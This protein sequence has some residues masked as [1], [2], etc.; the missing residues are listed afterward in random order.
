MPVSEL[1]YCHHH[2]IVIIHPSMHCVIATITILPSYLYLPIVVAHIW[3]PEPCI[4]HHILGKWGWV[5]ITH[6][7]VC[8][9]MHI[10]DTPSVWY[11]PN[12]GIINSRVWLDGCVWCYAIALGFWKKKPHPGHLI[13]W[14]PDR[15]VGN[16]VKSPNLYSDKCPICDRR[17][18]WDI[19]HHLNIG[20]IANGKQTQFGQRQ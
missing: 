12:D 3:V 19:N 1:W 7:A 14:K 5:H 15:I 8:L 6:T 4:N 11:G 18:Q 16:E 2:I 20:A 9:A 17:D 10:P 13:G